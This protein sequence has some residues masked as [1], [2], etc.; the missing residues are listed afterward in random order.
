MPGASTSFGVQL[1][2][3]SGD[4]VRRPIE[5]FRPDRAVDSPP[6]RATSSRDARRPGC[7]RRAKTLSDIAEVSGTTIAIGRQASP[8]PGATLPK[9]GC[10]VVIM[11]EAEDILPKLADPRDTRGEASIA[12][13]ELRVQGGVPA[14]DME[15]RPALARPE[16]AIRRHA[17]HHHRFDKDHLEGIS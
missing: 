12:R 9:L 6:R 3:S 11:G 10:A 2:G 5:Q 17:H 13:G 4:A 15:A 7:G 16:A 1:D 14:S 8:P